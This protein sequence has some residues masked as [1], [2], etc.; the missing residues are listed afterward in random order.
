MHK[1]RHLLAKAKI[2][3]GFK[4]RAHYA[5]LWGL[6]SSLYDQPCD[7][8]GPDS[9]TKNENLHTMGPLNLVK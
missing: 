9:E 2:A 7:A 3:E 5:T 6:K 1:V 4:Q 8:A